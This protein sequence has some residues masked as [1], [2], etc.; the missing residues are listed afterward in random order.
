MTTDFAAPSRTS[1][2]VS[3]FSQSG[4]HYESRRN[5]CGKLNCTKCGGEGRRTPSHGPYWY[6]C[7]MRRGQWHRIYL[8][9]ELDTT[10]YVTPNGQVDWKAVN[11]ARKGRKL[12]TEEKDHEAPGQQDILNTP[13]EGQRDLVTPQDQFHATCPR[14]S[15][16]RSP[17]DQ[18]EQNSEPAAIAT[19]ADDAQ[20]SD[21]RLP[22]G[23]RYH[24]S[25]P[26]LSLNKPAEDPDDP[27]PLPLL[28]Q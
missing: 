24:P 20:T 1:A 27:G 21:D 15:T 2:V 25:K 9:K 28:D 14:K 26:P 16:E 7:A 4:R 23:Y 17:R 10:K 12:A 18:S 8:G 6:L 5:D 3:A 19:G 13:N 22:I 11:E